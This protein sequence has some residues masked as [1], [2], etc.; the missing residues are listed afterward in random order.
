MNKYTRKLKWITTFFKH[1]I[2][3]WVCKFDEIDKSGWSFSYYQ[4]YGFK[5]VNCTLDNHPYLMQFE[6]VETDKMY[7]IMELV[8]K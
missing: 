1:W 3:T 2:W 7:T 4:K 6:T 5:A 8:I